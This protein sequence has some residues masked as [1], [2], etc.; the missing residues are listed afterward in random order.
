MET[1]KNQKPNTLKM[2][3]G[4]MSRNNLTKDTMLSIAGIGVLVV[5]SA[6]SPYFLH[7]VVR[8]Y[9]K[10]KQ[11]SAVRAR[12]KKLR[13]LEKRKLISINE[14]GDGQI[15]IELSHQGKQLIRV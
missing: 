5:A 3:R 8:K 1:Y 9:F 6:S 2:P 4:L 10:D 13:E 15:R 11:K 12:A 14:L 7:N